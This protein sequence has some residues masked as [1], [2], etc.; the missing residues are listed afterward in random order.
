VMMLVVGS[1]VA[2][3]DPP[4]EGDILV[5]VSEVLE[6]DELLMVAPSS[7]DPLVHQHLPACFVQP[8][9]EFPVL[10]LA[11]LALIGM[12]APHQSADFD[13]SAQ[14]ARKKCR[15][16]GAGTAE[17]LAGVAPPI[18]KIHAVTWSELG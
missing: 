5:L 15:Q 7:S 3:I 4:D 10:L 11:E 9:S 2:E 16:F 18:G 14:E 1:P 12:G 17:P 6:Q 13:A 8:F